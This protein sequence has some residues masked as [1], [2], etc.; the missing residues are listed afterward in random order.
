MLTI[1]IDEINSSTTE[2]LLKAFERTLMNER[3]SVSLYRPENCVWFIKDV[4]Q[5]R[6]P[7][8]IEMASTIERLEYLFLISKKLYRKDFC[9]K[10]EEKIRK[11][12]S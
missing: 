1:C 8:E 6:L 2:E 9:K 5:D 4:L 11:I 7:D 12:K 10:I 3:L